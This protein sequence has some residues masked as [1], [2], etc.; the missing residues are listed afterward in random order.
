MF[1][2]GCC[3]A[4]PAS[5]ADKKAAIRKGKNIEAIYSWCSSPGLWGSG[6]LLWLGR[7]VL[8]LLSLTW[9][10]G[11]LQGQLYQGSVAGSALSGIAASACGYGC[12]EG[13]PA[14]PC[15][16]AQLLLLRQRLLFGCRA[17]I[18]SWQGSGDN[19]NMSVILGGCWC[20]G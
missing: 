3:P 10:G 16:F 12:T 15:T 18:H 9:A 11:L 14:S 8:S 5:E 4:A 6:E 17:L 20:M 13:M 7:A 2:P 1:I 19:G